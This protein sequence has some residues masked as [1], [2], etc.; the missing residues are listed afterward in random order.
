MQC[1]M[2]VEI[3]RLKNFVDIR[4]L[5]FTIQLTDE[6]EYEGGEL[7]F[8]KNGEEKV[9][10]KQRTVIFLN[11][12][13]CM[14]LNQSQRTTRSCELGSKFKFEVMMKKPIEGFPETLLLL[15]TTELP[16]R[17]RP[18]WFNK[19]KVFNFKNVNSDLV[20]YT[21]IYDEFYGDID[22]NFLRKEKNVESLTVEVNVKVF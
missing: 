15:K 3:R 18:K 10:Q 12:I 4:K 9:A 5:S 2:I 22:K 6:E 21:I 1:I 11:L 19:F 20:N 16:D 14:R 8:Y 7:I 13:L 17:T